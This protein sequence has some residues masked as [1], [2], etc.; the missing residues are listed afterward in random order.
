MKKIVLTGGGTAGHV[1]PNLA[2]LPHLVKDGWEVHY[3]GTKFGVEKSLISRCEN[4]EYH[5][6]VSGKLRRYFDIKNF[7]DPFKVIFGVLQAI[8][9]LFKLKPAVIF[10]K[11]G[12]VSVPVCIAGKFCGIPVIIHESDL[13]PGLANKIASR[14]AT[15]ICTTFEQTS[16]MFKDRDCIHTGTPI[17]EELLLGDAPLGRTFCGF[18]NDK[19]IVTVMGGSLGAT[20]INNAMHQIVYRLKETFNIVHICGKGNIISDFSWANYKQYEYLNEELSHVLAATDIVVSRAGANS[21]IELL[22][23]RK[24]N[25]LI[26]LSR[27]VSRGDQIENALN[28]KAKGYSKLIFEEDLNPNL[29]FD[30]I[31]DLN[32]RKDEFIKAME[33]INQLNGLRNIL[34]ILNVYGN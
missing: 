4:V 32:N 26:P 24:P 15:K 34:N 28:F 7:S 29:L 8:I 19:P 22:A 23:L 11:G 25:L 30:E 12:F 2:L 5:T 14:F 18:G 1:T 6:I 33:T 13:T 20:A 9:I 21:I 16:L 31:I 3:I 27:G 10:S 17:R